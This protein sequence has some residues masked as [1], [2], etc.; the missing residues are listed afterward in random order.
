V[1]ATISRRRFGEITHTSQ[2]PIGVFTVLIF[3]KRCG[4]ET[5]RYA[6]GRCKP[7]LTAS[8]R[9]YYAKNQRKESERYAKYR[10]E[11]AERIKALRAEWVKKNPEKRKAQNA[12]CRAGRKEKIR[13]A[14]AERYEKFRE[15]ANYLSHAWRAANPE[16][17]RASSQ[18]NKAKRRNAI[19]KTSKG[20]SKRLFDLQKGMCACCGLPLGG[21]YHLD[22]IMPIAL[23]GTNE[24]R[25]IQLLR[26]RCNSQKKAKHPVDFM[27]ERGFLL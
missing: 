22:H 13:K 17:V 5:D 18:N 26:P 15:Y 8:S 16:K 7:C 1:V 20:L 14:S 23:G 9:E 12:K 24:D 19:G 10:S 4:K 21:N 11:N 6:S 27:Q 25:N 3:C 2:L